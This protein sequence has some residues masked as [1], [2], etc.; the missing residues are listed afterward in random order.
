MFLSIFQNQVETSFTHLIK[1]HKVNI[2]ANCHRPISN[3]CSPIDYDYVIIIRNPIERAVSYYNMVKRNR[4][5]YSYGKI[6]KYGK[7]VKNINLFLNNCWEVNNQMTLYLAGI[8]CH[9]NKP[10][11]NQKIYEIAKKNLDNIKH[12]IFF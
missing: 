7:F 1:K 4:R 11:V 8:P 9:I 12:V 5:N 3:K 6:V 2:V 10:I